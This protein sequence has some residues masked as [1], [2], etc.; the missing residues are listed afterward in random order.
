MNVINCLY[1]QIAINMRTAG[2]PK[3][4]EKQE[5]SPMHSTLLRYGVAMVEIMLPKLIAA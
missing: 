1:S 4:R 3:A 5:S 2:R